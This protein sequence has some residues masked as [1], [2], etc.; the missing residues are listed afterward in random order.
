M[1]T[2]KQIVEMCNAQLKGDENFTPTG[3]CGLDKIK[4]GAIAYTNQ[5][6][7]FDNLANLPLG[8]LI[9]NEKLKETPL[10]FKGNILYVKNPEWAFTQVLRDIETLNKQA[11]KISDKAVID[12]SAKIGKGV[13]IGAYAVIEEGAVIGDGTII[14]PNV[15]VGRNVQIGA[16]CILYPNVVVRENCILKNKVILQPGAVIGS[17]G[18][19]YVFENGMHNKI[20]QIGNVILEDDVEIGANTTIDRAK[21]NSTI[22]GANTKIDNLVQIA[23]NVEIGKATILVSQV[24]IAGSTKVGNGVIMAGQVGVSGHLTIGDQAV[25]GPQAGILGNVKPGEKLLGSPARP[26]GEYMRICAIMG[27]LPEFYKELLALKKK[28]KFFK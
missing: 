10:P 21:L 19:G 5:T 12:P 8:A 13:S 17:D 16:L 2:L 14:Y 27:K 22:I 6:E 7:R 1:K 25:L 28:F 15:Y 24:G 9:V 23:H 18:F 11:P 20:P 26:Y 3:V 4:E